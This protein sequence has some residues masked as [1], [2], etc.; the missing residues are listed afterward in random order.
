MFN[1]KGIGLVKLKQY[2][3]WKSALVCERYVSNTICK[4]MKT[5][6]TIKN[7]GKHSEELI[8]GEA[9][10]FANGSFVNCNINLVNN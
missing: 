6:D 9:G 1:E 3:R 8:S 7:N 2:G 5:R 4:K 10:T